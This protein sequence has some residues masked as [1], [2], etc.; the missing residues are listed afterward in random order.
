[1]AIIRAA[2]NDK[3]LA[4]CFLDLDG[5]NAINDRY[6]HAAGDQLLLGVTANLKQVLRGEDTLA[7][8]GGD[9]FVVLL[10]DISSPEECSLILDRVLTAVGNPIQ[11]ED[12]LVSVSASIGVSLYPEDNADADTLLRHADQAMYLAKEAGKNRF[13]LFDP[14]SDRKAQLHRHYLERLRIALA[15]DE[16]VLH[17]QPKVDLING[18]IIGTEALIRWQQPENGLVP[19]AEFLPHIYRS[20]LEIPLGEWVIETALA[21]AAAW[22]RDGLRLTVSV[23]V[24]ANHLLQPDFHENLKTSLARHPGFPAAHFELE[25][26]ETAAIADMQQA[27]AILRRCRELGVHFALD[28]FGTGYSSLTYLRKLPVDILK[29]DQSFVRDMLT[30]PDD[31][32]IVEGVIRLA[33]AFNRQVIAEG[34]ETLEHGVALRRLGCR[35]AQGYGIARPMP[36]EQIADWVADWNQ[37]P[38]L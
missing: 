27:V 1:Q 18:A 3:S 24:S 15:R 5:F 14:E 30:D 10:S 31:M 34:V 29:I 37:S 32:G 35:F 22:H 36:A 2:R 7:R 12:A 13:H 19:P 26:L 38:R 21:Q 28:D 6:G 9:E 23:N 8:L 4:V 33:S 17:Y 16:F 20:D 25:V 11:L